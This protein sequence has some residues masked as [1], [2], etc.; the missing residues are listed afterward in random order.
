MC[1]VKGVGSMQSLVGRVMCRGSECGGPWASATCVATFFV[2]CQFSWRC[3][4][5]NSS[6]RGSEMSVFV[7]S[8]LAAPHEK[9]EL[10]TLL[11]KEGIKNSGS[12]KKGMRACCEKKCGDERRRGELQG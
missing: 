5:C 8:A 3:C 6:L 1:R 11:C 9:R 10:A 2:R 12:I 7:A 4:S